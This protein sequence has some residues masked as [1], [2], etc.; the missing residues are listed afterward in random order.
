VGYATT[1]MQQMGPSHAVGYKIIEARSALSRTNQCA[2]ADAELCPKS[3]KNEFNVPL[4]PPTSLEMLKYR[5]YAQN[6]LDERYRLVLTASVKPNLLTFRK[7]PVHHR[8][9]VEEHPTCRE[10]P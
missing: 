10:Q 3:Y 2:C 6:P 5:D 8:H 9:K 1:V 4:T 7:P